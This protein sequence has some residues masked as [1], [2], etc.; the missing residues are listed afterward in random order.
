MLF[1]GVES[2]LLEDEGLGEV[3]LL[4]LE[5]GFKG[6]SGI[7]WGAEAERLG[8]AQGAEESLP[9]KKLGPLDDFQKQEA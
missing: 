4:G 9:R 8:E 2:S 3:S 7:P 1:S 6:I 5:E